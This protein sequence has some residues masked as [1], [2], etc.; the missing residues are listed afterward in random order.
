MQIFSFPNHSASQ[1]IA[2]SIL[3]TISCRTDKTNNKKRKK[4][5]NKMPQEKSW[6]RQWFHETN[7]KVKVNPNDDT[8]NAKLINKTTWQCKVCMALLAQQEKK[9][10]DE[11]NEDE[12]LLELARVRARQEDTP[13]IVVFAIDSAFHNTA[14]KR[15]LQQI[16]VIEEVAA[17]TGLVHLTLDHGRRVSLVLHLKNPWP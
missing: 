6:T 13:P 9:K 11:P 12:V 8:P 5:Q 15:H 14:A 7:A 3:L 10:L 1:S 4:K 16:H 17:K 2:K